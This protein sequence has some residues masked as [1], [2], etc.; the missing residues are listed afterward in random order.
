MNQRGNEGMDQMPKTRLRV[1]V[2]DDEP[3]SREVLSRG[4]ERLGYETMVADDAASAMALL[5]RERFHVVITDKNMPGTDH[6][7]EGGLDVIRFAKKVNPGC[8]VLM[9]T[10]YATVESAIEAMQCGAFDY[11]TKSVR[12]NALKEKL[13]RVLQYQQT[14]DPAGAIL[15]YNAFL[16]EIIV[17]LNHEAAGHHLD[18]EAKAHLLMA[19]QHQI[20]SIFRERREWEQII[21]EQREALASI[22]GWVEEL[23]EHLP[24]AGRAADLLD[25]ISNALSHRV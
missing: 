8:A 20:D 18:D 11:V 4:V 22:D 10:S 5:S 12:V 1:L 24:A 25:R 9:M 23:R 19:M 14:I 21:F 15:A 3:T 6:P 2:V 7:T 16:D 17:S 13:D